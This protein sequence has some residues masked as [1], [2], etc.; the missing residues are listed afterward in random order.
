VQIAMC[1]PCLQGVVRLADV[2]SSGMR[3]RRQT[4]EDQSRHCKTFL[5][6]GTG[7]DLL[8]AA[9]IPAGLVDGKPDPGLL[10]ISVGKIEQTG[11]ALQRPW[12]FSATSSDK[13]IHRGSEGRSRDTALCK[14]AM[15]R[16]GSRSTD[17]VSR[18]GHGRSLAEAPGRFFQRS[19]P[20]C[21]TCV[22]AIT[23][24]CPRTAAGDI[25]A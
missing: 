21:D 22:R 20:H 25:A 15:Q 14:A 24:G 9:Q 11:R 7:T 3:R 13:P 16:L 2:R 10:R 8:E 23:H 12:R 18:A 5:A 6:I 19:A 4:L 1:P 17:I